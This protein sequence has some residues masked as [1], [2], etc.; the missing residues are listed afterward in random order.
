MTQLKKRFPIYSTLLRLY[1]D[2]YRKA[3]AEEM[4]QTTADMLDDCV[5]LSQRLGIWMHV[6]A[7]LPISASKQQLDYLGGTMNSTAPYVKRSGLSASLLLLPA[8]VIVTINQLDV[9]FR[10]ED[11]YGTWLWRSPVLRLWIVWLPTLAAVISVMSLLIYVVSYRKSNKVS[12]AW[13]RISGVKNYWQLI[14]PA[15]LSL[16]LI[17][18]VFFHDSAHC[19]F[20]TPAHT[21]SGTNQTWQCLVHNTGSPSGVYGTTPTSPSPPVYHAK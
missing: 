19:L 12:S 3:Y 17:S 13:K 15:V 21:L 16:G 11:L 14:V 4:L 7:E 18:I 2:S 8:I 1:P 10:R 6:A 9:L 20:H 5:S